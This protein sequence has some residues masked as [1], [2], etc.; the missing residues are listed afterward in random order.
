MIPLNQAYCEL[1]T[2]ADQGLR[3]QQHKH[4]VS[5]LACKYTPVID[6]GDELAVKLSQR[7]EA[8]L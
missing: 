8:G 2:K 4:T 7:L 6:N 3:Y 5:L 1:Q